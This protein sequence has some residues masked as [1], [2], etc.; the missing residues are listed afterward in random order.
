MNWPANSKKTRRLTTEYAVLTTEYAEH[1]EVLGFLLPCIPC[2]PWLHG[3][4]GNHPSFIEF[5]VFHA[6]SSRHE[7]AVD[8]MKASIGAL[9]NRWIVK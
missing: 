8:C 4:G 6:L 9:D 3:S 1:T 5:R 2:I 7:V